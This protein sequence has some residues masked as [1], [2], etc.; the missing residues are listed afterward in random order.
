MPSE[1]GTLGRPGMRIIFPNIGIK[2]PAPAAISNSRTVT[3]NPI[4][5]PIFFS[6]SLNDFCVLAIQI[7]NADK[8]IFSMRFNPSKALALYST[9]SAPYIVLAMV[10]I[11]SF[12]D[13]EWSYNGLKLLFPD[14]I[15]DTTALAKSCV[16]LPPNSQAFA[17]TALTFISPHIF[18]SN[19]IS[20]WLSFTK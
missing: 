3:V 7:G 20:S 16:P 1:A 19:S 15:S 6:L 11:F 12:G 14:S 4:G 2:N 13:L 17:K 9:L 10:S 8:P 18:C 5:R